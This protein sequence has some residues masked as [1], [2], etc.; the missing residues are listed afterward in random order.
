[1]AADG[2]RSELHAE[3]LVEVLDVPL[4]DDL[5]RHSQVLARG[6]LVPRR[7]SQAF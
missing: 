7:L 2:A 4:Q 5:G 3:Y 1:M 6:P